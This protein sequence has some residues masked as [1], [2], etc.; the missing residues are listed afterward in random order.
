MALPRTPI[1]KNNKLYAMKKL[2]IQTLKELND[3]GINTITMSPELDKDTIINLGL[4]AKS[5]LIVYGRTPLM[6]MNYCLLH[7]IMSVQKYTNILY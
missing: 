1:I 5:E 3:L 6:N 7:P 4:R 2:D